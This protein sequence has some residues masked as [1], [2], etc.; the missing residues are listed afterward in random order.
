MTCGTMFLVIPG[1][2]G[3][4]QFLT[5]TEVRERHCMRLNGFNVRGVLQC[6][7]VLAHTGCLGYN[8]KS[9]E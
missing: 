1:N 8:A 9:S 5:V 7:M 6:M 2:D 4:S 3:E